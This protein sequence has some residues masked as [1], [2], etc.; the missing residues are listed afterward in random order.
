MRPEMSPPFGMYRLLAVISRPLVYGLFRL[1]TQGLE[2]LPPDGFVLSANHV[3]NFDPWPLGIPLFPGRWLRF[4]AKSEL[5][6]WPLSIVL[7]GA[8][9]FKVRR[10]EGDA[11]AIAT[12]V[13]LVRAGEIV[14]MFP[15]GTRQKKGLKKTRTAR[16]HSG[17]A[18][19]AH[20]AGAPLVP[21]AIKG[22]DRLVRLARWQVAY[23]EPFEPSEDAQ[24]ATE[25]LMREIDDLYETL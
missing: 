14:V 7:D 15:E 23:G 6:W 21:A 24:A 3:S 4:M 10:G 22:T 17:A 8:G 9:A 16:P 1:E 19:I 5:Y 11:E 13:E 12:A 20:L 2:R 25:R 18:R